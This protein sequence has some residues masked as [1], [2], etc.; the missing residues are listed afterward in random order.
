MACGKLPWSLSPVVLGWA[1][2][3]ASKAEIPK[4]EK[5]N[6]RCAGASPQGAQGSD[7]VFLQQRLVARN[8][9]DGQRRQVQ[10]LVA[11]RQHPLRQA[12]PHRRALL[13]AV[14]RKAVGKHQ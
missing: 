13:Q 6:G 7:A 14:P 1:G 9:L 2:S 3:K 8:A 10:A 5:S 11:A 4:K 12:A